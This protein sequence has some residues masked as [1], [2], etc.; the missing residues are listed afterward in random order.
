MVLI[1]NPGGHR[2]LNFL[3]L[4]RT[5]DVPGATLAPNLITGCLTILPRQLTQVPYIVG[6]TLDTIIFG[7]TLWRT[8]IL[9]D[10]GIRV[11][12]V[13]CLMRE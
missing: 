6:L 12:I 9:N 5:A 10:K 3:M 8:W 2:D 11:P 7:L 1:P 4:F 13:S